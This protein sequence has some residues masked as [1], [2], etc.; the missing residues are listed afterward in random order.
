MAHSVPH[1]E[2]ARLLETRRPALAVLRLVLPRADGIELMRTLPALADLPVI[3]ISAYRRVQ[4]IA[5]PLE[6]GVA[7]YIV[8]PF[9]S[10]ELVVR[11]GVA[12]NR[13]NARGPFVLGDLTIRRV[14]RYEAEQGQHAVACQVARRLVAAPPGYCPLRDETGHSPAGHACAPGSFLPDGASPWGLIPF[15]SSGPSRSS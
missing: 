8:K 11:V 10:P 5:Q 14:T 3:F 4:T 15:A 9:S 13:H 6:A 1:R 7:D 12:L 2:V